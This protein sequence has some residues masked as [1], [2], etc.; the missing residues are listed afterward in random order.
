MADETWHEARLIPT[1][2]FNGA[3]EQERRATSALLA[4]LTAVREYGRSLL[5]PLGAPAGTI[6]TYS[7]GQA[8]PWREA[9]LPRRLIRV[10]YTLAP[11]SAAWVAIRCRSLVAAMDASC[12][13][14]PH[15]LRLGAPAFQVA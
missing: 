6:Q 3:E 10:S 13:L 5:K 7:E 2:G 8:P 14:R 9:A 11:T 12:R 15:L 1:S 4:V